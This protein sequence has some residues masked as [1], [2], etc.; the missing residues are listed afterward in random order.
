MAGD[1]NN[2]LRLKSWLVL[3]ITRESG[4]YIVL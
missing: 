4:L 2:E 3:P 1:L